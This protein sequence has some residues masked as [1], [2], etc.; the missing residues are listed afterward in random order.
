MVPIKGRRRTY[1]SFTREPR[2]VAGTHT[3]AP[4]AYSALNHPAKEGG[5]SG[6]QLALKSLHCFLP[7]CFCKLVVSFK[8][9][10]LKALKWSTL[11]ALFFFFLLAEVSEGAFLTIKTYNFPVYFTDVSK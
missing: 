2:L 11:K 8:W 6:K 7:V 1:I 4:R 10:T 9:S 3:A 5:Y